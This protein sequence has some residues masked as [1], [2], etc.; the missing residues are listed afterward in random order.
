MFIKVTNL[1]KAETALVG[2][3]VPAQ[4]YG[5][6]G[7][8]VEDIMDQQGYNINRGK[9]ADLIDLEVEVKSRGLGATSAQTIGSMLPKDIVVTAYE[10]SVIF[11]KFQQQFRVHHAERYDGTTEIVSARMYNFALPKIQAQVKAAYESARLMIID[12]LDSYEDGHISKY[13]RGTLPDGTLAC[14]Y[15]EKTVKTSNSYDFRLPDNIMKEFEN[16]AINSANPLF[17]FEE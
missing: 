9:G 1:K 11:S 4:E 13:I 17:I 5:N 2:M 7:A 16:I 15:W 12:Q 14:G 10:D 8:I 3:K 6:I